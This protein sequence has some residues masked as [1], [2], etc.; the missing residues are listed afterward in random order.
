MLRPSTPDNQPTQSMS[1]HDRLP[2]LDITITI[3]HAN[4]C[5]ASHPQSSHQ[6]DPS[7]SPSD[8]ELTPYILLG[9]SSSTH[10]LSL[11][12]ETHQAPDKFDIP[13]IQRKKPITVA[14]VRATTPMARW[15]AGRDEDAWNMV[16]LRSGTTLIATLRKKQKLYRR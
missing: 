8:A 1:E 13:A 4:L 15:V 10:H 2:K 5:K 14:S 9:L 3:S 16:H 6:N 7:R 12:A 11:Q